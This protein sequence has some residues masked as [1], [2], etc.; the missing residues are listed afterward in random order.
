MPN[1]V[2]SANLFTLQKPLKD[3]WSFFPRHG[4]RNKA[5]VTLPE[6]HS[7]R[8][9]EAGSGQRQFDSLRISS[10]A[11][12]CGWQERPVANK[13]KWAST[14]LCVCCVLWVHGILITHQGLRH[15]P[16]L[17]FIKH[18]Q[19][20]WK[21]WTHV[22][23]VVSTWHSRRDIWPSW[24]QG[25][26]YLFQ[27]LF[28]TQGYKFLLNSGKTYSL[29]RVEHTFVTLYFLL[30]WFEEKK[31]VSKSWRQTHYKC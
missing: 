9:S 3:Y 26:C 30:N 25:T 23:T 18:F 8:L 15:I 10:T 16:L 4:S 6:S 5:Y 11:L 12:P 14:P 28:S 29:A 21:S 31:T 27:F 7:Y 17:V 2:P 22:F 13:G 1:T 24:F 19:L 20:Q